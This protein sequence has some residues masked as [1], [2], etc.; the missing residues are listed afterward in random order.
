[1]QKDQEKI[2]FFTGM[3]FGEDSPMSSA[4]LKLSTRTC[5]D[6]LNLAQ[7][8]KHVSQDIGTPLQVAKISLNENSIKLEELSVFY[9]EV[10]AEHIEFGPENKALDSAFEK[11][12]VSQKESV[13]YLIEEISIENESFCITVFDEISNA[14]ST[15]EL[16][17]D[18]LKMAVAPYLENP[19]GDD[20]AP[21]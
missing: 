16:G 7:A 11:F 21:H 19:D 6:I 20:V 4:F 12:I 5:L 10:P 1:M 18:T 8:M 14:S 13:A 15:M 17:L 2:G 9:D 3:I